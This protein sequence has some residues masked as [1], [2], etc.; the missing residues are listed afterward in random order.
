MKGH[1]IKLDDWGL[2]QT[3]GQGRLL[4]QTSND[5][6]FAG[7]DAVHGA[8]LVVTGTALSGHVSIGDI[9]WLTGIDKQVKIRRLHAKNQL[10]SQAQVGERIALNLTGDISKKQIS[11]GDWLLSEQPALVVNKVLI[12]VEANECLKNWQPLHLYHAA[13][14]VNGHIS[15]LNQPS[16]KPL[17][18]E[19]SLDIPL[20]LVYNSQLIL[21]D[22]SAQRTLA[23]AR[24][25]K[26]HS[27]RC[28]KHQ[29][30]FF[31]G[32]RSWLI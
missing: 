27:P 2:I 14:H 29:A 21:R 4:T 17:L 20:L 8:G 32:Y 19:L 31:F 24:L 12:E 30:E 7:A 23:G 18:A 26:L 16:D 15:L 6:V 9:L 22:I 11:R 13:S 3:G 5:K 28:G 1:N 25:I 10:V